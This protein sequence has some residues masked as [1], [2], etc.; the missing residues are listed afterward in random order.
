MP[1]NITDHAG[2][3]LDI[4]CGANKQPGFVGIDVRPLPG[5]DIVHNLESYPWPLPD[6]CVL[7]ACSSHLVEHIQPHGGIF[8]GFMNEAWRVMRDGGEFAIVCPHGSSQGFLQDPTHCNPCNETTWAYF[9]PEESATG[10]LL[11]R[12][13]RPFP[14]KIKYLSWSPA[15]N[16]EVVLVKRPWLGT[17]DDLWSEDCPWSFAA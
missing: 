15:A 3:R 12:I 6:S 17:L 7:T 1:F 11:W 2:I 14:W 4:G 9:D 16:I 8:I 10:G 5:V 13:Y